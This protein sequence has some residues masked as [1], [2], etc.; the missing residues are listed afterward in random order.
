MS[1]A[2]T[3][4]AGVASLRRMIAKLNELGDIAEIAAPR[5]AEKLE[6][7]TAA[8]IAIGVGPDGAAWKLTAEGAK[9][10]RNAAKALSSGSVGAVA[11]LR[12]EGPEVRHHAGTARGRVRRQILPSRK[13]S[14]PATEAV[15]AIASEIFG[16]ITAG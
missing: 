12:L 6:E 4:S 16:E 3:N 14:A 15:R 1:D 11:I 13:L 5:V 8:N 7:L 9:P 2:G 10:L